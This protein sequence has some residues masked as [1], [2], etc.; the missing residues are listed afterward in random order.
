MKPKQ[1]YKDAID[2]IQE[3]QEYL[4]QA[5]ELLKQ[6]ASQVDDR[7]AQAYLV[8]HLEIM[9]GNTHSFLS[10]DLNC[11]T[12]IERLREEIKELDDREE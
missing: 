10:R 2:K 4:E 12:W 5:Y 9:K 7:N 3:A 6:A 8:D 1:D 11:D